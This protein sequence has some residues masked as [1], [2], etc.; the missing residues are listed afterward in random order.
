M[1]DLPEG[2]TRL[3]WL[4]FDEYMALPV[5]FQS[6]DER[7]PGCRAPHFGSRQADAYDIN[8]VYICH[9]NE[10][11]GQPSCGCQFRP[12]EPDYEGACYSLEW[13]AVK[14]VATFFAVFGTPTQAEVEA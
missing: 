12:P 5:G 2:T 10:L 11:T 4:S 8:R 13:K 1:P 14:V 6:D 3:R 9:G 7:C